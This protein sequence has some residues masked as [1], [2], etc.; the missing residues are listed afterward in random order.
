MNQGQARQP[1]VAYLAASNRFVSVIH[2][3]QVLR[4][5]RSA[6]G[7]AASLRQ[8][9]AHP[10]VLRRFQPGHLFLVQGSSLT[11]PALEVGLWIWRGLRRKFELRRFIATTI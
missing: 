8:Q 2:E 1:P 11:I 6:V 4:I 5:V 9:V 10:Q 3:S 7:G